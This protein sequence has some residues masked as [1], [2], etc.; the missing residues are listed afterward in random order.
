[1]SISR[2]F[3]LLLCT[4][5]WGKSLYTD[6]YWLKLLHYKNGKSQID[7]SSFFL[8]SNGKI[9]AKDEFEATLESIKR[10]NPKDINSTQ[11]LYPART[12]WIKKQLPT[13]KIEECKYLK[14]H[15]KK[16]DFKT[17]Y[18]V[19]ASSYMNSPASMVGHT[20]LRFDKNETTPLLSYAL[21]YSAKID[22]DTNVLYYAYNGIFGGFEGRYTIAPYHEM[23]KLYSDM[24]HRDIWEYKLKLT[25]KEIERAVLHM[26]EIHKYYSLYYFSSE[27]CSYNLLWFLELAKEDLK[28]TDKFNY[29]TAPMDTIKELKKYGLIEKSI[30]RPSKNSKAKSIYKQINNKTLAKKFLE[31]GNISIIKELSTQEQ[32]DIINLYLKNKSRKDILKYRSKLGVGK[33]R[34]VKVPTDP[35]NA[36]RASKINIGLSSDRELVYGIRASYHDIYDMDYDFNEGSYISFFNLQMKDDSIESLDLIEIDSLTHEQELYKQ[37]SWGINLKLKRDKKDALGINLESKVGKSYKIFNTLLFIEPLLSIDYIESF[38]LTIDYYAGLLKRINKVKF[39]LLTKQNSIESFMTYQIKNNIA[40][41]LNISKNN[42]KFE[43]F[44]Y[45]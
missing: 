32:I 7:D 41:H 29:I 12:R 30:F 9:S 37:F 36:N 38:D 26:I 23:V 24:E 13:E 34:K 19:Y 15:L 39:G 27:N 2:G 10:D 14:L 44:Y 22:K 40:L 33:N 5:I 17:I 20:F 6:S 43:L 16:L 21:N 35:I 3:S 45:F 4:V 18:L 11:C 1:M 28:L 42:N 31:N 8:S 25:P